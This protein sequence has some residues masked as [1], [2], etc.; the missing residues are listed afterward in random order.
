[1]I[2]TI[3][4]IACAVCALTPGLACLQPTPQTDEQP[5]YSQ[6][7]QEG[8]VT[9]TIPVTINYDRKEVTVY[10]NPYGAPSFPTDIANG[11][12]VEAG[13]NAMIYYDRLYDDLVPNYTHTYVSGR[14]T[15]G[16]HTDGVTNMF[17]ELRNLMGTTSAGTT[18][19]GFI[20]GMVAYGNN[21]NHTVSV[22]SYSGSYYNLSYGTLKQQLKNG[23]VAVVFV[24]GYSFVDLSDLGGQPGAGQE[25]YEYLVLSGRHAVLAYGY[26][27]TYYYDAYN[28]LIA[29]NLFLYV[30]TGYQ[31]P[32]NAYLSINAYTTIEDAYVVNVQ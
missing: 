14:F 18:I 4:S 2:K 8:S 7:Y 10:E 11:C 27:E 29:N 16:S 32:S 30:S 13:G 21:H 15:Y 23:K 19:S 6:T 28:K 25:N 24:N 3:A 31:F 22:T 12:T 26:K 1:M 9:D 17:Y 5:R 20:S